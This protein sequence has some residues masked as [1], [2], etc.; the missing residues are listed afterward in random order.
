MRW[1]S[2]VAGTF[3]LVICACGPKTNSNTSPS[4]S[5]GPWKIS[6]PRCAS[7][8]E[9][10]VYP[11]PEFATALYDFDNLTSRQWIIAGAELTIALRDADCLVTIKRSISAN[12]SGLFSLTKEKSSAF[13]PEHCE[14]AATGGGNTLP[15]SKSLAQVFQD[16]TDSTE[17]I[18]FTVDHRG[19]TLSLTTLGIEPL[20]SAWASH[21][22][23]SPDALIYSLTRHPE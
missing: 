4:I 7:T 21:G 2:I 17:D 16:S 20:R 10:P 11:S 9:R 12:T 19:D 1:T 6:P 5:D 3:S 13:T 14:F 23:S 18:A 15:V 8:G 22:C